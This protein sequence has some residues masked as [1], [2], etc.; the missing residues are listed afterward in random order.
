MGRYMFD[1]I[2]LG[3]A[4]RAGAAYGMQDHFTAADTGGICNAASYDFQGS[5]IACTGVTAT[6]GQS[7][8]TMGTLTVNKAYLCQCDNN[9]AIGST[10]DCTTGNCPTD[11]IKIVSLQVTASATFTPIFGYPGI[12][13]SVAISRTAT[14]RILK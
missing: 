3:N 4:A 14:M 6:S 11:Q 5:Q 12:P 8:G 7:S 10:I 1:G 13:S 2:T 9:G